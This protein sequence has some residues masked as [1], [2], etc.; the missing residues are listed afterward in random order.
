[1]VCVDRLFV[2]DC[3]EF[4]FYISDKLSTEVVFAFAFGDILPVD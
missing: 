2:L 4:F 1:M 3:M